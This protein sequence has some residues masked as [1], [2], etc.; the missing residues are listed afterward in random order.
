MWAPSFIYFGSDPREPLSDSCSKWLLN[1]AIIKFANW[2]E[3]LSWQKYRTMVEKIFA[4]FLF[5]AK[6]QKWTSLNKTN[7]VKN[8]WGKKVQI[9]SLHDNKNQIEHL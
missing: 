6:P 4:I 8:P 2:H 1:F 3:L 5:K 7:S 9:T